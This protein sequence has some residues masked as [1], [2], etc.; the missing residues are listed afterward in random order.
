MYTVPPCIYIHLGSLRVLPCSCVFIFRKP[1]LFFS[2][3]STAKA[4]C[5]SKPLSGTLPIALLFFEIQLR[6]AWFCLCKVNVQNGQV[7]SKRPPN[8]SNASWNNHNRTICLHCHRLLNAAQILFWRIFISV[9]LWLYVSVHWHYII[10]GYHKKDFVRE[11]M[12]S[13]PVNK[14]SLWELLDRQWSHSLRQNFLWAFH[15]LTV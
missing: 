6:T 5:F 2:Q 3:A 11:E 10:G 1:V 9:G 12:N 14:W 8:Y 15:L 13:W 4:D 7:R